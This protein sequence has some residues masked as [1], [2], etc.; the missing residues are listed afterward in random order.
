[1]GKQF[2][3]VK[4]IDDLYHAVAQRRS[5]GRSEKP[6][7][8]PALQAPEKQAARQAEAQN[9]K[10]PDGRHGSRKCHGPPRRLR[11][12]QAVELEAEQGKSQKREEGNNLLRNMRSAL[13]GRLPSDCRHIGRHR[14]KIPLSHVKNHP[15]GTPG[16]SCG[17]DKECV[18]VGLQHHHHAGHEEKEHTR[19]QNPNDHMAGEHHGCRDHGIIQP[20]IQQIQEISPNH[21]ACQG[22]DAHARASRHRRCQAE[23]KQI[24][25]RHQKDASRKGR[26]KQH[27]PPHGNAVIKIRFSPVVEIGKACRADYHRRRDHEEG[28]QAVPELKLPGHRLRF[29]CQHPGLILRLGDGAVKNQGLPVIVLII[30]GVLR[31]FQ[32]EGQMDRQGKE[33]NHDEQGSRPGPALHILPKKLT[34]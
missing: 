20:E 33:K 34:E 15:H 7:F 21:G 26:A 24:R 3:K 16:A 31:V 4:V 18:A 17:R 1:M 6:P 27:L 29:A 12:P 8:Q 25:C 2:F 30:P 10:N 9:Q 13:P 5:H 14:R 23:I 28:C 22:A 19:G 11:W 32:D